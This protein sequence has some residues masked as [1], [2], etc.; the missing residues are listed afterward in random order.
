MSLGPVMTGIAGPSLTPAERELLA[1]PAVGGVILFS[2]N[3]ESPDQLTRLTQAI[4]AL[5]TPPLL[6]AVDQEGGPVQR[7]RDGFTRLPPAARLGRRYDDDP[8][9]ARRL[10]EQCG[11]LMAAELRAAGVDL[12]FA[13]VLDLDYGVSAVIG[14][15]AFHRD[16]EAVA[17]LAAHYIRGMQEAG[18]AAVG[19]HFPGHGGVAA[20]SHRALPVDPRP[21]V[22]LES[23]DLLPFARLVG[24]R[25]A[26]VMI[27]HVLY[28]EVDA[29]PAGFSRRWLHEVLRRRLGFQGAVFSDDLGMGAAAAAGDYPTRARAALAAGCDMILLCN[30]PDAPAPVLEAL[31]DYR[32]PAAGLR[33]AH[34]HGARRAPGRAQLEASGAW[35]DAV[36]AVR[37]LDPDPEL[38]LDPE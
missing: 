35:R 29:R 10:A 7:F 25:L 19:K 26:G 34:L 6:I 27:A 37:L 22:D 16:P 17:D 14:E 33:L 13:P 11:W 18:M 3:Y 21:F 32:D 23:A 5:R 28:P 20:D 2:R 36:E 38:D 4:H 15:R 31:S 30:D 1:H 12:S 24:H 9:A 8:A